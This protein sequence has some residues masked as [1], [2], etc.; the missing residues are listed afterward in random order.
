MSSLPY[1]RFFPKDILADPKMTGLSGEERG[2]WLLFLCIHWTYENIVKD[3][4]WVHHR[5]FISK[6]KWAKYKQKYITAGLLVKDGDFVFSPRLMKEMEISEKKVELA[7]Q[8]ANI[9][10]QKRS[11]SIGV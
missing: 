5:L 10:W 4:D 11:A 7:R 8:S 3:D 9:R 6:P 1:M 2:V